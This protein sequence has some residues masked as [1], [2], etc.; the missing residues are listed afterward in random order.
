M[1]STVQY[2]TV[3]YSTVQYSTVPGDGAAVGVAP[4][5]AAVAHEAEVSACAG[6][7]QCHGTPAHSLTLRRVRRLPRRHGPRLA[8]VA[9]TQLI[10]LVDTNI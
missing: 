7:G 2:S 10:C 3:Q 8:H 9:V 5:H 4:H 1:H 6:L